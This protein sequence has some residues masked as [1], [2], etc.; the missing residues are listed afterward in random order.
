MFVDVA[1]M[2]RPYRGTVGQIYFQW[3]G[4][5]AFVVDLCIVHDEYR[6][7]ARVGDGFVSRNGQRV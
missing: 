6:C 1:H 2:G 5:N 3:F 7:C 4:R